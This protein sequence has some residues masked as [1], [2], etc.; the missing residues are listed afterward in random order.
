[1]CR[2]VGR[3][4]RAQSRS[5]LASPNQAPRAG[6][7]GGGVIKDK[8]CRVHHLSLPWGPDLPPILTPPSLVFPGFFFHLPQRSP[9]PSTPASSAPAGRGNQD[10]GRWEPHFP[11]WGCMPSAGP[12]EEIIRKPL[13][14]FRC[15][16][17]WKQPQ[18]YIQ[19]CLS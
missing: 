7:W 15:K 3:G 18:A 1:M 10:C 4:G 14:R 16:E 5:S 9:E 2:G 17:L 13:T 8:R 11:H 6:G 19:L 12:K